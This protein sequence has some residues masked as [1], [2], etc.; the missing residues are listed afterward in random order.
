MEEKVLLAN[1]LR[2]F[3]IESLNTIQ[4]AKPTAELTLRPQNGIDVRL[5]RR[6]K[7]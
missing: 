6:I 4:E 7:G 5:R 1:L 2:K 3:E